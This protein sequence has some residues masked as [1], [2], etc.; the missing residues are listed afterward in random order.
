[1]GRIPAQ[2]LRAASGANHLALVPAINGRDVVQLLSTHP[3]LEKRLAQLQQ[4][5]E[6]L[7]R[8]M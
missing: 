2:D 8:P 3:S 4:I 1:M 6:D 7:S 5:S